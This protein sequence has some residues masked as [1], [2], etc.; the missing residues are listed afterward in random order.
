MKNNI[1]ERP[2]DVN[3]SASWPKGLELLRVD[4]KRR[5]FHLFTWL[6]LDTVEWVNCIFIFHPINW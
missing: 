4:P 2:S 3:P 1:T 6:C 5:L